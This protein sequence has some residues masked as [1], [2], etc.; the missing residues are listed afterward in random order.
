MYGYSEAEALNMNINEMIPSGE[1]EAA[2]KFL[3]QIQAGTELKPFRTKRKT[4]DGRILDIWLTATRLDD[5]EGNP[6]EIA[7]TERDLGYLAE[8]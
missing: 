1:Y 2:S 8:I 7:T 4:K 3:Q 6:M 5:D